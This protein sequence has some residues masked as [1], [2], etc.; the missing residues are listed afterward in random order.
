[1]DNIVF[2]GG[3]SPLFNPAAYGEAAAEARRTKPGRPD[4]TGKNKKS[5]GKGVKKKNFASFF[6][7]LALPQE[8]PLSEDSL[9]ELLDT[10]HS[11]GDALARRPF[12]PEIKAYKEAIRNFVHYV[13]ENGFDTEEQT[14]ENISREKIGGANIVKRK[15]YT[16]VQVIDKKLEELAAGILR[17]QIRQLEILAKQE[18]IKGLLVDLMQ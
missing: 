9:H 3:S 11:A 8:L 1:M 5:A 12:P 2:P 16:L 18:E 4:K 14:S 10:V 15:K 13:V 6:E 17:G 7:N